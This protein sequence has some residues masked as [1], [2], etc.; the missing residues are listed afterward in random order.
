MSALPRSLLYYRRWPR[1]CEIAVEMLP[2]NRI[3]I[4]RDGQV[5]PA[6]TQDPILTSSI[7]SRTLLTGLLLEQHSLPPGE[8]TATFATHLI[9]VNIGASY[10]QEWRT[11]GRHGRVLIP[12]GGVS[13]CNEQQGVWCNWDGHRTFLALAI[14]PD[15]MQRT[16]YEA[17]NYGVE[18]KAEPNVIDPV[19]EAFV[20]AIYAEVRAGC[21]DPLLAESLGSDLVAFLLR[22]YALRPIELRKFKGGI[23]RRR[24]DRVIEYI[25]ASLARELHVDEL[26]GVAEM[27]PYYFGKLFKQSTGWTVHQYVIRRRVQRAMYLLG[28]SRLAISNVGTAVGLPN[29]SQ[30]TRLFRQ[31]AGATPRRYRAD[32]F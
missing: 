24:L 17:V 5:R 1:E 9:G 19:I 2:N 8:L 31:E 4:V 23:P 16:V 32:F 11:E 30:F 6:T 13:L 3:Q 26:A 21:P 25:E 29:Q 7:S 27:S 14:Q 18:L 15:V 10:W 12:A 20:M 28:Q 22:Q